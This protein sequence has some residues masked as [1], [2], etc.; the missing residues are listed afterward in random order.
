ML[1]L[2]KLHQRLQTTTIYVTHDQTEA[3]TM[4]TRLV[5]MKNGMIQQV[6]VP[7][8]VYEN[9]KNIFVG[10]FIGSPPMNFLTGTLVK[11]KINIGNV[12][13]AIPEKKMNVLRELGYGNKKI[14]MGIRPED[15]HD[16]SGFIE[17]SN[18][19][20]IDVKIEVTELLGAEALVYSH[21]AGQPL[22]ARVHPQSDV[23]PG[24]VLTL[25][26]DMNKVHFFDPKT[27][28]RIHYR[29]GKFVYVLPIFVS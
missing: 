28:N 6:G 13:I 27:E 10:G 9:P 8:E 20:I 22:I 29:I 15:F 2:Q 4:A 11:N 26:M 3:M 23:K 5:V 7:K 25:A 19:A 17:I 14:I 16:R 12:S 24:Q 1:R 18:G 21:I